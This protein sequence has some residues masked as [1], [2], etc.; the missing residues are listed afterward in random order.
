VLTGLALGLVDL[1]F[2]WLFFSVAVLYGLLLSAWAVLLEEV[3]FRR[4]ARSTDVL[5]LL[6]FAVV[7]AFGYRQLTVWFR[8]K[9]FW[10]VARGTR[11]WGRMPREGFVARPSAA[12]RAV[13]SA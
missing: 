11:T 1:Q 4:Y 3:S 12:V 10:N 2:A 13:E 9:A 6:F 8:L 5:G 7:E